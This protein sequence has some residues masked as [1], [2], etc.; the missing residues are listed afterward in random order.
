VTVV[1]AEGVKV[2][3][4]EVETEAGAEVEGEAVGEVARLVRTLRVSPPTPRL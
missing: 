1:V 3:G 4:G 2:D